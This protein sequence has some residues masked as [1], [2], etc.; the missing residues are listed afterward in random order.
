[1]NAYLMMPT[2]YRRT[3]DNLYVEMYGSR[4]LIHWH[5]FNGNPIIIPEQNPTLLRGGHY[6]GTGIVELENNIWALP[7]GV[8]W[9][10]H[11][12]P[13]DPNGQTGQVRWARWRE[14]GFTGLVVDEKGE[15]WTQPSFFEGNK[16]RI[17]AW[18]HPNGE[19]RVGIWDDFT[20]QALPGLSAAE[21]NIISGN[22]EDKI[23]RNVGWK[24]ET[25]LSDFDDV[26]VRIHFKVT[27]GVIHAF[28]FF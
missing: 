12:E 11:N 22:P 3:M 23:W 2:N 28:Q 8:P 25:D 16:L 9:Y 1:M 20:K 14:D 21:S 13:R 19:I 15:F 5:R 7:V 17:N 6:L 10:Y 4:D 26:C 24:N 18:T 27:R